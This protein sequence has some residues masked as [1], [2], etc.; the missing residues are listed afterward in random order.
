MGVIL[1]EFNHECYRKMK[2]IMC[3]IVVVKNQGGSSE[4]TLGAIASLGQNYWAFDKIHSEGHIL[5][6]AIAIKKN[7]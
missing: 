5:M 2:F 1:L 3:V 7:N 4:K 6:G